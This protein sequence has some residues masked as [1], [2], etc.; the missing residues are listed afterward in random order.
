MGLNKIAVAFCTV[1]SLLVIGS[2]SEEDKKYESRFPTFDALTIEAPSGAE[3]PL[4]AG[5][6]FVIKAPQIS[7][8]RHLYGAKYKWTVSGNGEA[9]QRY[10]A[11]PKSGQE[12][13]SPTDTITVSEPGRYTVELMIN[14]DVAGIGKSQQRDQ[15]FSDGR[16]S[17]SYIGSALL[18]RVVLRRTFQ[19]K[20]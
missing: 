2:C 17:V 3:I 7:G 15:Q 12:N 5:V 16:G 6:P 14:Y 10:A 20:E 11:E 19:V 9:T 13:L 18:Y 8:G 1:F 4:K